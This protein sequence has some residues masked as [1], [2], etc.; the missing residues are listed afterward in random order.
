MITR[1][2]FFCA[3]LSFG[4]SLYVHTHIALCVSLTLS[5]PPGSTRGSTTAETRDDVFIGRD[6]H[7][8]HQ[9]VEPLSGAAGRRDCTIRD[10]YARRKAVRCSSDAAA[11]A[12]VVA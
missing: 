10:V 6:T 7:G 3:V 11:A 2:V 9:T 12:A 4:L 1:W 8:G 5:F